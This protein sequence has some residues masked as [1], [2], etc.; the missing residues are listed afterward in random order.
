MIQPLIWKEWHEQRWKLFFGTVMLVF[1]TGSLFAARLSTNREVLVGVWIIGGVVLA[2][3]SAMGV[4]APE[5]TDR[6]KT[7]L[8]SK[9]IQPWKSF[10]CKWFFGWLNF[11][12]PMLICTVSLVAF[13]LL[14]PSEHIFQLKYIAK[15]TFVGICFGTMF[16]TMTCCLPPRKSSE[17]LVG[18]IGLMIFFVVLL[19]AM[20]TEVTIILASKANSSGFTVFQ[21]LVLYLSPG[22]FLSLMDAV[23]SKMH[24]NLLIIEQ[25]IIFIAMIF[26]GLRKWKRSV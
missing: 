11:A 9:P 3:Y 23:G 1:F 6:T 15:G 5:T 14:H 13:M 7:F 17:A 12:V 21:E 22:Y 10:L 26:V 25:A 16:Y 19:H 2:L 20:L 18:F 8:F 4:F 24:P